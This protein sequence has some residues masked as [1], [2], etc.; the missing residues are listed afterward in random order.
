MNE[1]YP[2]AKRK[3]FLPT[4]LV[5]KLH[6]NGSW[7]RQ[8]WRKCYSVQGDRSETSE[9]GEGGN[10]KS[11]DTLE[12]LR[13]GFFLKWNWQVFLSEITHHEWFDTT[14]SRQDR[15]SADPVASRRMWDVRHVGLSY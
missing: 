5:V 13:F 12:C 4:K 10:I 6:T 8:P 9:I 15:C 1:M 2:S 7:L 11:V 14:L 3:F